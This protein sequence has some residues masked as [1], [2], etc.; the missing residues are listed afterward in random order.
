M[1]IALRAVLI[2]GGLLLFAIA[3]QF[4]TDPVSAGAN[5]GLTVEG[6][7]GL[8]SVRGDFTSFF[9]ISA[10]CYIWGA[11]AKRRDPLIIGAALMLVVL[12]CRL[13]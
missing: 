10:V 12:V 5:F 13:I 4:F 11:V 3:A 6:A 1:I 2:L 8:T 7:H 9:L